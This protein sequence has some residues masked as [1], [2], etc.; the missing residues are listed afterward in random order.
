[1][2]FFADKVI[3]VRLRFQKRGIERSLGWIVRMQT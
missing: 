2:I 1:M 3:E